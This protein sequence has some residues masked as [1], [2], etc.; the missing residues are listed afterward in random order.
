LCSACPSSWRSPTP[1][2]R[3]RRSLRPTTRNLTGISLC[4]KYST[5]TFSFR[6]VCHFSACLF[7]HVLCFCSM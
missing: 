7:V 6:T 1:S 5:W 3:R 4:W 2:Q